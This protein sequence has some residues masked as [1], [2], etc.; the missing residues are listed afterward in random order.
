MSREV[1][2]QC[3][4]YSVKADVYDGNSGNV[5][6]MLIGWTSEKKKY[7]KFAEAIEKQLG[8]TVVVLDYSGHGVSPFTID[9]V[10]PAENFVEVIRTFDWIERELNPSELSVIGTSY[11][12]FM[13]TQLTKYRE[14]DR[15]ILRVPA[16][17]EPKNFYTKWADY[18]HDEGLRYRTETQDLVNHPL[19]KRAKVFKGKSLVVLHENDE[20]CPLNSTQAFID[21]FDAESW[22]WPDLVHGFASS[23]ISLEEEQAYYKKIIDWMKR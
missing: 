15:I 23:G 17:Y 3:L 11:G 7:A 21:A 14:F 8:D 2:I 13:A 16:L 6:L 12:S 9:E 22:T 4:G 20:R 5:T 1:E 10:S 19:L 18:D